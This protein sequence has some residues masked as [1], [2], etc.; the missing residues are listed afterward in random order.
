MTSKQSNFLSTAT[1]AARLA[2]EIILAN[3]GKISKDDIGLKQTADFVTRV[4]RESED[5]I[6]KKIRER[7][8]DHTFLAEES[9]KDAGTGGY[10]WVIDP[11]D[12][13]TNYIHGYPMFS[14]SIALEHKRE[15]IT[16]VIFDPLRNERFTAGRGEG[17]FLNGNAVSVSSV[18][19]MKDSLITTGFPFRR[20]DV[21]DPYLALFKNV[22]YKVSDLRRAGSA[23][24]DLAYLAC[25]RCDGFFEIGLNPWDIAAGSLLVREAG[26]VVTDF[27]GGPDYLTTGNIV[28][29]NRTIHGELLR[30]VRGTFKGLID[31]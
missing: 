31:K 21:I 3:L 18:N 16:A 2:G 25:G 22:F 6:I 12:G 4:D 10:R 5:V 7:F 29:G 27:G 8:P 30:E 28:A 14:V 26:G 15:I 20:K 17:A 24:L 11:L 1:E 13:T 23:A 9:L 19:E